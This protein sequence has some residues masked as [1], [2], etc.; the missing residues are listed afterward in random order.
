MNIID[1]SVLPTA[2]SAGVALKP[3]FQDDHEICVAVRNGRI[4]V[5]IYKDG[6]HAPL[7][8]M[9]YTIPKEG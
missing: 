5:N 7:A 6:Q 9:T 4:E 3:S 8:S 1:W 2:D